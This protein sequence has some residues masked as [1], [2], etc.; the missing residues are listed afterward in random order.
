MDR[1]FYEKLG[2]IASKKRESE[3]MELFEEKTIMKNMYSMLYL[4]K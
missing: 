4:R 2:E 1:D 3:A